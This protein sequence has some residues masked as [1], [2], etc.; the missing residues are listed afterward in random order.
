MLTGMLGRKVGMTQIFGSNGTAIPVTVIEAGPCTITQ[1][2]TA[3]VDG[4]EAVQLGFGTA[5]HATRPELGH[6]G[7]TLE[8]TDRQRKKQQRDQAK[9]RQEARQRKEAAATETEADEVE[10]EAAAAQ[11]SG[12]R[13]LRRRRGSGKAMG[14]FRVLREVR[15]VGGES[16]T[17]GDTITVEMFTPGEEVDI[18]GTSKGKGFAGVMKRHGFRGGPRTHGQSDRARA[19]GSIGAGTTPGRVLKGTRMAGRM[20]NDRVTIKALRV[21]EAD[22]ARNLLL[23]QGSVPGANGGIV[24]IRKGQAQLTAARRQS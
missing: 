14:P 1:V 2:K 17:V 19:P 8:P 16:P 24:M 3:G 4:Y 11:A 10:S 5:K 22:A 21:V 7:H 9:A 20:G 6:L 23:V 15:M 12:A 18:I 13:G